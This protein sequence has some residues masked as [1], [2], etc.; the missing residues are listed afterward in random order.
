MGIV[1]KVPILV[2]ALEY[3]KRQAS[4]PVLRKRLVAAGSELVGE[5]SGGRFGESGTHQSSDR[6]PRGA[7]AGVG[8]T[9]DVDYVNGLEGHPH[10]GSTSPSR[11]SVI[12]ISKRTEPRPSLSH[13][14]LE[15]AN[16]HALGC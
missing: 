5:H 12:T 16:S 3:A 10:P 6:S 11:P 1:L 2:A 15:I 9:I 14:T 8:T 7:G 13:S 4:G